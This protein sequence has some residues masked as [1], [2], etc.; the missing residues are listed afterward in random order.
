[1][2]LQELRIFRPF[3][4]PHIYAPSFSEQIYLRAILNNKYVFRCLIKQWN[5]V[6][7]LL[8]MERKIYYFTVTRWYNLIWL[9]N[10]WARQLIIRW[11]ENIKLYKRKKMFPL[12]QYLYWGDLLWG[13]LLW[14]FMAMH[15]FTRLL[16]AHNSI[17]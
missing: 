1:M 7:A 16:W 8:K 15:D 10:N 6:V 4:R 2:F 13:W 12:S 14:D 9:L 5:V 17:M 3:V 11:N